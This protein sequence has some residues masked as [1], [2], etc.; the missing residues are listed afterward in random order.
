MAAIPGTFCFCTWYA[1]KKHWFA[2]NVVGL[3]FCI[4]GIDML[5]L[6]SFK[7]GAILLAGLFV[8]DIFCVFFT[9]VMAKQF[10]LRYIVPGVIGILLLTFI[11]QKLQ[12]EVGD[13]EFGYLLADILEKNNVNNKGMHFDAGARTA[14]AFV[15]LR[16]DGE[17]EFMFYRNPSAN[18]LLNKSELDVDLIRE[19]KIF[20]YG[21]ISLISEP[22]KSAHLDAMKIAKMLA[23]FFHMILI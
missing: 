9:P 15:T 20:H 5:S 1:L 8:Y 23:F 6:G 4:Q 3:V 18:M 16:A 17:R 14:L 11:Q 19:A 22:C 13:D 12:P 21:S 7:T 10:A 2:N